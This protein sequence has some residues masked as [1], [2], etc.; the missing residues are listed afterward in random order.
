MVEVAY[1]KIENAEEFKRLVRAL[2]DAG[3][4]DLQR[5]MTREIRR[6]GTPAMQAAQRRFRTVDV[7]MVDPPGPGSGAK[8]TRLRERVANAT[9]ISVLGRGIS[10]RVE[11]KRVDNR[12]GR[13]L[14]YGIDGLGRW[15]HPV[16]ANPNLDKS[17]W[18]WVEQ[19]GQEVFY[20]TLKR[21]HNR[22][23]KAVVDAM[24]QT[25]RQIEG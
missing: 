24:E 13:A 19:T 21:Y 4:G 23:Q 8:S 16:H 15:R 22:W 3:R 14:T 20:V 18:T 6:A 25:K 5:Q 2:K 9:R 7:R 11:P 12:Y 1:V 10:I 17:E